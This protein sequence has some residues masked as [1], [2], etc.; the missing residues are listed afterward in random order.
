MLRGCGQTADQFRD[1]TAMN[2][3]AD[4]EGFVVAYPDQSEARNASEC[5]NWFYDSSTRRGE[6]EA[7]AVAGMTRETIDAA[8]CDTEWVSSP[9]CRRGRR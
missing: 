1:E 7:A 6:G 9:A 4:E 8:G 5:W 2:R 3:V